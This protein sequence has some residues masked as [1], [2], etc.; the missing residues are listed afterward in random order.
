MERMKKVK[1]NFS[2][3]KFSHLKKKVYNK[4]FD[5]SKVRCYTCDKK[6]HYAS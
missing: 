4:E 1:K 6:G 3:K 2:Q 5:K